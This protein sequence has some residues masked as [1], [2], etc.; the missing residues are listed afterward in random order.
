MKGLNGKEIIILLIM[1]MVAAGAVLYSSGCLFFGG[2]LSWHVRQRE[3]WLLA[4][5]CGAMFVFL[6]AAF[7]LPVGRKRMGL[8]A[9]GAALCVF[10]WAH[11]ALLA[12]AVSGAYAA[13]L[14]GLGRWFDRHILRADRQSWCRSFLTGCVL[15]VCAF[16]LMSA[17]GVGQISYLWVFVLATAAALVTE[18]AWREKPWQTLP[19]SQ[20]SRRISTALMAALVLTVLCVQA[21]RMN[22]AVDFDSLW[23]GVRSPY[24]LD[25]G[26][27]IYENMGTI[28]VVYTYS[29]G[30]EV[31]T[32]PL[33]VLPSYS[34]VIA[35]N[36]WLAVGVL[37]MALE[38]GRIYMEEDLARLMAVFL[39]TVP[40]IMNMSVTAKS[41]MATLLFQ[42]MMFYEMLLCLKTGKGALCYSLAAFFFTWTLK[43]TALVF[44]TA[45]MGMS[46][47]ELMRIGCLFAWRKRGIKEWKYVLVTALSLGALTGIWARTFLITGLPVTSVFSSLLTKAGFSM[48]YPFDVQKIPNSGAGQSLWQW[49]IQMAKRIYGI[50]LNPQGEDMGHVILAWG[51]LG[52]WLLLWIWFLWLFVEKKERRRLERRLDGYLRVVF[53]PFLACCIVSL[54][55]LTQVDGNY[56]MLFYVLLA[57]YVFRLVSR[58][59]KAPMKACAKG[60]MVVVMIFSLV[61]MGLTNWN[62]TVGLTPVSWLHRGYYDH[63]KIERE[64]LGEKGGKI[65]DLLA[66][67][68]R[69]RL[70]AVGEHP[71]CL[72]FPCSAQS[73]LDITGSWGNVALVRQMDDFVEFM[74]Y[75][76]TDYVYV[77][78]GY[79]SR[80]ERAWS[81]TCD[82]IEYGILVPVCYEEGSMLGVVDTKGERTEASVK[83][84]GEF[85]RQYRNKG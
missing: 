74:E 9:A 82:L 54:M 56:F 10:L 25:N 3:T 79:L 44:S 4:A 65:W 21:G 69:N 83:A 67:N 51:S 6:A 62:W 2:V 58:C 38:I 23:Y 35:F 8:R 31:L 1:G 52:V 33:S 26:G 46:G 42:M 63:R 50:L 60:C 32:L 77:Q 34:F 36:L 71:Q 39:A 66:E 84:L 16:C 7:S 72:V 76:K 41:D 48:K 29:K 5:E 20:E 81:L 47:V 45:I 40:G 73:Y 43:P 12:L 70:I 68:P 30:F 78:A 27:G 75:A 85:H 64:K 11:R 57:V 28:G 18:A 80:E 59:A 13:Y 55:M 17:L 49:E 53:F 22:I 14:W 37:A 61:V 24:I 19:K 15:A